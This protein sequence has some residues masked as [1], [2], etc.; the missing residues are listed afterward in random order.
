MK[1]TNVFSSK[2]LIEWK[3]LTKNVTNF[4]PEILHFV[5]EIFL[6]ALYFAENVFEKRLYGSMYSIWELKIN[7]STISVFWVYFYLGSGL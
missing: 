2:K 6:S 5:F 7:R 1:R 3:M 4:S